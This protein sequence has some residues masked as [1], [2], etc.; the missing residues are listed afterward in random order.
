MYV[1]LSGVTG[2]IWWQHL[3]PRGDNDAGIGGNVADAMAR[4]FIARIFTTFRLILP[5]VQDIRIA[6]SLLL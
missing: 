6:S 3:R 5:L 2:L 1:R 4:C